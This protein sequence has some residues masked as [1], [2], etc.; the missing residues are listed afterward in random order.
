MT[1]RRS[2]L[3]LGALGLV[4][5]LAGCERM[6]AEEARRLVEHYNVVVS[7][8]YRRGDVRLI[9]PVVGP[10]EGKKLTGLIGARLDMGI[11]LDG[12]LLSLD[13]IGV[14]QSRNVLRVRTKER[15]RY[16]DLRI[17]SGEQVG[18]ES[19]DRYEMLYVFQRVDRAWIVDEIRFT[20]PPV[21]GRATTPWGSD[22]ARA[23]G[24]AHLAADRADGGP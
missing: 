10:N 17:G 3:M 13:V 7:E 6:S 22:P 9:D 12:R 24:A 19:V 20:A 1:S 2:R 8:A 4:V 23:H 18:Q 15:W 5:A 21:V 11:T 16:R 14:E